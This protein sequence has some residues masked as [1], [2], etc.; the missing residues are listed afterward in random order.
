MTG[1]QT[2]ALPI[3]FY[4]TFDLY[5]PEVVYA[6]SSLMKIKDLPTG[7]GVV[8][9]SELGISLID[10]GGFWHVSSFNFVSR[11]VLTLGGARKQLR[12]IVGYLLPNGNLPE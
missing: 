9:C 6:K 10:L 5:K 12:S 1:V 11:G 7:L 8:D 3:C 4:P 2:C